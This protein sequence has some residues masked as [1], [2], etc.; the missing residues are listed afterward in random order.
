VQPPPAGEYS[1]PND[2]VKVT[3][4]FVP[5]DPSLSGK[6]VAGWAVTIHAGMNPPA[7]AVAACGLGVGSVHSAV[8]KDEQGGACT[9]LVVLLTDLGAAGCQAALATC[10]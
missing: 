9:P 5:D 1:C 7:A 6:A 10:F 4:D 8:R 3:F 2:P